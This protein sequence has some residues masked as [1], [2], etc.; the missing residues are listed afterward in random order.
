M[1]VS[2]LS[3][4]KT[5]VLL[6]GM[7]ICGFLLLSSC[8]DGND[9]KGALPKGRGEAGELILL[10]DSVRWGGQIGDEVR[11][12]FTEDVPGLP[13][14]QPLFDL[15]YIRPFDFK[16]ILRNAKNIVVIISLEDNS[17][18]GKRLQNYFTKES[19]DSLKLN[20]DLTLISKKELFATDQEVL[21]IVGRDDNTLRS[22]IVEKR[23][24][25]RNHFNRVE[26]NRLAR[27]IYKAKEEKMVSKKISDNYQL[28]LKVPF[29]YRIAESKDQF[30]WLRLVGQS[31]DRNIF[32][33]YKDYTSEELFNDEK[34][35]E[36]RDEVCKKYI[37][38][39][40]EK[41]ETYLK[42]EL[43]DPPIIQEVNF[44]GQYSK[45]VLGRWRTNSIFMGGPFLSYV[46][47][48]QDLN[49]IYYLEGFIYSPG[50]EQ[51]E[52][53]REMNVIIKTLKLSNKLS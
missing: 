36:W 38:G 52:L 29:G 17:R 20:P 37:Y 50:E 47:V 39:D 27:A 1:P 32:I 3:Y 42:T 10:M 49:R 18:E 23:S 2:N 51:R 9:G 11:I 5:T 31:V 28:G 24:L 7:I 53:M 14:S 25:I 40:P 30:V 15:R 45:K 13:R 8:K 12:T 16:S 43:R 26:E 35:I 46:I 21:F 33:T 6:I 41:P 22:K 48:D 44:N 34:I 4:M 19:L